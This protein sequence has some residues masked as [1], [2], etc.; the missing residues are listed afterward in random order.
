MQLHIDRMTGDEALC[1]I[2]FFFYAKA[3]LSAEQPA[4]FAGIR[5]RLLA[6]AACRRSVGNR[7][8][9]CLHWLL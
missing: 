1:A 9:Y 3:F 2:V 5:L 6:P 7:S 8:L 4:T